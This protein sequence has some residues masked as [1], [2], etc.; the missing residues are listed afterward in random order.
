MQLDAHDL[1][2]RVPL[3]IVWV[4]LLS[5]KLSPATKPGNKRAVEERRV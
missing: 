5:Y 3:Y 1:K 4:G 2:A